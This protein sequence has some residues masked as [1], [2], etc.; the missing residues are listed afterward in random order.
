MASQ[1]TEYFFKESFKARDPNHSFRKKRSQSRSDHVLSFAQNTALYQTHCAVLIAEWH[2][3][4]SSIFSGREWARE[5]SYP[6]HFLLSSCARPFSQSHFE[7]L[8]G[9]P[10][11]A[12]TPCQH[13]CARVTVLW[14][15]LYIALPP[16]IGL[17]FLH[18]LP[19]IL[20]FCSR[21]GTQK[22]WASLGRT[23]HRN[24]SYHI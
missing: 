12:T 22:A 17:P 3:N 20:L 11:A 1:S 14:S 9:K 5:N 7:P 4:C 15:I 13:H 6:L 2:E 10:C 21:A 18:L 23:V 16:R 24:F 8:Y 19:T